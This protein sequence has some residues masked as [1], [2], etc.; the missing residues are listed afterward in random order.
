MRAAGRRRGG[1]YRAARRTGIRFVT[2]FHAAYKFKSKWKQRY[3]SVMARG[4]RV[5]AISDF[6]AQHIR[7]NYPIDP[8]RIVTIPRGLD[9]DKFN[10]ARC[11]RRAHDPAAGKPGA[12][13]TICRCC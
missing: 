6:I 13:P 8:T 5:I 4:D 9:I 1:A 2:T 7:E 12:C 10:R 3:N 11:H